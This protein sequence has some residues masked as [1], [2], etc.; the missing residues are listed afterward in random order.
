M[1]PSKAPDWSGRLRKVRDCVHE[2]KLGTLVVSA[3]VHLR[4]LTGFT[5][6]LGL[7]LLS[8]DRTELLL[9]LPSGL[10]RRRPFG[11]RADDPL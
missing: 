6:S 9:S 5:G 7:L 1:T 2:L 3:P 11:C 8:N 4:Y 10:Q